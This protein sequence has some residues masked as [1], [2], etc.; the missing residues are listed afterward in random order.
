MTNQTEE[1]KKVEDLAKEYF[2]YGYHCSE[3]IMKAFDEY[4]GMK[5]GKNMLRAATGLAAGMGKA[6]CSCG[7]LTSGA[8]VLSI[9]YGRTEPHEDE[10]MLF[11]L[12]K[13][14][15]DRFKQEFKHTCCRILTKDVRWGHPDHTKQCSVYV[16]TAAKILREIVEETEI[17]IMK[18]RKG[19]INL[20]PEA[21]NPDQNN[22][23]KNNA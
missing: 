16:Y 7:T 3:A 18:G 21:K 17:N 19:R 1:T 2:I 6:K 20:Y 14:L 5:W 9:L 4:Y 11:D 15:H 23:R 10:T 22:R 12:S 13:E 8:M